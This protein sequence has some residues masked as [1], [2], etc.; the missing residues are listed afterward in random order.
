MGVP[1]LEIDVPLWPERETIKLYR[2]RPDRSTELF[3]Y[4][5]RYLKQES[6]EA[7]SAYQCSQ[8]AFLF[9]CV[10]RQRRKSGS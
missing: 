9:I 5:S 7:S 3:S 2:L 10:Q 6:M 4:L 1:P 8:T